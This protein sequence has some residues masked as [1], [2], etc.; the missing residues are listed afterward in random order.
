MVELHRERQLHGGIIEVSHQAGHRQLHGR[1]GVQLGE[2]GELLDFDLGAAAFRGHAERIGDGQQELD[3]IGAE[4][5]Q[6]LRVDAQNAVRLLARRNHQTD[7]A[8]HRVVEQQVRRDKAP[9]L[10]HVGNDDRLAPAQ[11]VRPEREAV[12]R[13]DV[14]AQPVG[15]DA[16]AQGG[17][18]HQGFGFGLQLDNVGQ[19]H[20]QSFCD[21]LQGL[22]Q[23]GG[24]VL[25]EH[26]ELTDRRHNRLL[27]G[28]IQQFHLRGFVFTRAFL[29][30]LGH[31]VERARQLAQLAPAIL[32]AGATGEIALRQLFRRLEQG[33]ELAHDKALAPV[34]GRR[35]RQHADQKPR[36]LFQ[37]QEI[38]QQQHRHRGEEN[39]GHQPHAQAGEHWSRRRETLHHAAGR[40]RPHHPLGFF[41]ADAM[42]PGG[43]RRCEKTSPAAMQRL[44]AFV[45][46]CG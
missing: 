44:Q 25:V 27:L 38:H 26:G 32:H 45:R 28:A 29:Q 4:G 33:A 5:P 30:R 2:R 46:S 16:P 14:R 43:S 31:G 34:P 17:A 1:I 20:F 12:C 42:V 15:A 37:A 8:R 7:A 36:P 3:F 40:R 41:R 19:R 22:V 21:E 23:E 10:F 13:D 9:L 39:R 11:D 18:R 35:Q 6:F 24:E